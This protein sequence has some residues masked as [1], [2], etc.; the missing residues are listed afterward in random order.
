AHWGSLRARSHPLHEFYQRNHGMGPARFLRSGTSRRLFRKYRNRNGRS[1][2]H[3]RR[4]PSL[5]PPP[6]QSSLDG[7]AGPF[8]T[9]WPQDEGSRLFGVPGPGFLR[10][11][12]R[13]D[14]PS[15]NGRV[16]RKTYPVGSHESR[17]EIGL[18]DEEDEFHYLVIKQFRR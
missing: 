1:E 3:E 5:P 10:A 12:P 2:L 17:R 6:F 7:L 8:R 11:F 4:I 15:Q 9:D 13:A 18:A 16:G 14:G